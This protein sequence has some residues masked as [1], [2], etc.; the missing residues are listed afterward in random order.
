MTTL[1][2]FGTLLKSTRTVKGLLL[3]E[4]AG[5]AGLDAGLL[6]KI[7][8][9]ERRATAEQCETFIQIL[10]ADAD[11]FRT[12]WLAGKILYEIEGKPLQQEALQAALELLKKQS[13]DTETIQNIYLQIA[14]HFTDAAFITEHLTTFKI[15]CIHDCCRISGNT[16]TSDDI[17]EIVENG[18]AVGGKSIKQHFEVWQFAKAWPLAQQMVGNEIPLYGTTILQIHAVI[19]DLQ[20]S[21]IE[22]KS[23]TESILN[24]D[25]FITAINQNISEQA[26]LPAIIKV[27][28]QLSYHY[29]PS[30]ETIKTLQFV[31]YLQLWRLGLP[32]QN[33]IHINHLEIKNL[34][35]EQ[36]EKRLAKN[37]LN[38]I[39]VK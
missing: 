18:K 32:I 28:A 17:Y 16:L 20:P 36:F 4:M 5:L 15:N 11:S 25:D 37:I 7:E 29:S 2:L 14:S 35:Q 21:I 22:A 27:F 26:D 39:A 33:P 23:E 31:L 13:D 19:N 10:N 1:V 12:S 30:T 34:N 3:K 24:P 8:N 9:N 38:A 6:S